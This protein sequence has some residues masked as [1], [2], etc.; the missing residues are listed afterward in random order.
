MKDPQQKQSEKQK[1]KPRPELILASG[2]P[3]R[4]LLLGLLDIP[5]VVEPS[6]V[7]ES[8][9]QASSPGEFTRL[10]ARE[11]CLDI[12]RKHDGKALVIG[13]DTV[14]HYRDDGA[15]GGREITL[16][17]PSS[18]EEA[19]E[20]LRRLQG[21]VHQVTTAIALSR[22]G[23]AAPEIASKTTRVRFRPLS[24]EEIASYV[25]TGESLDKA[26]AYA[27]Q[28][29]GGEFIEE[30]DGDLQ[31]VIGLPLRLLVDM[32]SRDYPGLR[33]PEEETLRKACETFP[34]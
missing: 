28:G 3:R 4:R 15:G 12:A 34:I 24:D 31:N 29:R 7:D 5:F 1:T 16:G 21:R 19:V 18:P 30:V 14:V 10:A 22:P 26:G 6:D 33:M 23:E 32:L 25:G 17:K 9:L 13:S 27:V 11:K 8:I 2:S 20:M